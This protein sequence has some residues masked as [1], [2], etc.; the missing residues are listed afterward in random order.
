MSFKRVIPLFILCLA[1]PLTVQAQSDSEKAA[2]C[3]DVDLNAATDSPF[4][5]IPVEDQDGTG[6]C[7]AYAASSIANYWHIKNG[8]SPETG[9]HP[10]YLS[11]L[12]SKTRN[13]QHTEGG[14]TYSSLQLLREQ[15]NCP[16][17][18]VEQLLKNWSIQGLSYAEVLSLIETANKESRSNSGL[19]VRSWIDN[20]LSERGTNSEETATCSM[21]Q[22]VSSLLR[23]LPTLS[24]NQLLQD[25]FNLCKPPQ[26]MNPGLPDLKLTLDGTDTDL[27]RVLEN[28]LNQGLPPNINL[29]SKMFRDPGYRGLKPGP[30][31][32]IQN[33]KECGNH[34]VVLT[35]IKRLKGECRYLIRNSWGADWRA[36]N[37]DCACYRRDGK[38]EE[39]CS[40]YS[41]AKEVVGCWFPR[42]QVLRNTYSA[43][44]I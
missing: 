2:P 5:R 3:G 31:R 37:Q 6:T 4:R 9:A 34:A 24:S 11:H 22:S 33:E 23:S 29:C 26:P 44:S 10:M 15:G 27:N 13:R 30:E 41:E 28:S 38:Y 12:Y 35:G 14:N 17:Q 25:L 16:N 42:H 1:L 20:K 18:K 8:G 21:N 19:A 32:S 36:T 40:D 39:I 43:S 7:Y